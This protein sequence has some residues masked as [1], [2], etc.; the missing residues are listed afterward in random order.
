MSASAAAATPPVK[1]FVVYAPDM[2][3]PDA[4]QRRLSVRPVHLARA[5]EQTKA[6][7][8]SECMPSRLRLSTYPH[9]LPSPLPVLS[10]RPQCSS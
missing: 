8:V 2:T 1:T 4:L 10:T 5:K 9:P 7:V 6:G 3:D